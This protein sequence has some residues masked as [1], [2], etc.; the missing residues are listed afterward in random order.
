M[1]MVEDKSGD[2]MT[3]EQ[4]ITWYAPSRRSLERVTLQ[5]IILSKIWHAVNV[6]FFRWSW[7]FSGLRRFLLHA[8]GLKFEGKYMD[9]SPSARIDCPWNIK[10]GSFSSVGNAAWIYALDKIEI[11]E[12]TC[13]GEQVR[14]LTGYHDIT[15]RNFAFKTKPIRIGSACWVATAATILP[16]VTIGDGAVVAAGAVVT[17]DVE[18][19]TV[20]GGNPAKFIKRRIM[21]DAET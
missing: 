20:V 16:G 1:V 14:L 3:S 6:T 12:K 15:T 10:I 13:I 18:P 2:G 5:T 4:L 11:G 7:R 9:F 17:K 8:F 21:K 19:W